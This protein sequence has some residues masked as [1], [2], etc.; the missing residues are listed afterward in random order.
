M[1]NDG[2]ASLPLSGGA[3][4]FAQYTRARISNM[5]SIDA[6]SIGAVSQGGSIL[7]TNSEFS[8]ENSRF[9]GCSASA[10]GCMQASAGA[11][12]SLEAVE[13][14]GGRAQ[15]LDGGAIQ[16]SSCDGLILQACTFESCTAARNGGAVRARSILAPGSFSIVDSTVTQATA[17]SGG[18]ISVLQSTMHVSNTT[19]EQCEAQWRGGG[20]HVVRPILGNIRESTIIGCKAPLGGG[21]IAIQHDTDSDD[22]VGISISNSVLTDNTACQGLELS[23]EGF[24]QQCSGGGGALL[25]N[26]IRDNPFPVLDSSGHF[27]LVRT[28]R[29]VSL[30]VEVCDGTVLSGN[31]ALAGGAVLAE[32]HGVR[33]SI[34]ST[35]EQ[36]LESMS[37]ARE[38]ILDGNSAMQRG[39][40]LLKLLFQQQG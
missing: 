12:V 37:D 10:G 18:G 33:L 40:A 22:V 34:H 21:G 9:V 24:N 39:G 38:V 25:V 6:I 19:F 3:D 17:R 23:P 31:T 30:R 5:L 13:F 32:H 16:C 29:N 36:P 1:R 26:R 11:F 2:R 20:L 35:C 4:L 28:L 27:S 7:I 8:A 15:L 14:S